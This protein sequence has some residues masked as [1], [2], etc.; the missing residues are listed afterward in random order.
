MVVVTVGT[1]VLVVVVVLAVVL[2]VGAVVV[3]VVLGVVD[4][5]VVVGAVVVVLAVVLVVGTVVVVVVLGVVDVVVVGAVVVVVLAVVDVVGAVVLVVVGTVVVVVVEPPA[6]IVVLARTCGA[7]EHV[8][9]IVPMWVRSTFTSRA[10]PKVTTP[11]WY[12]TTA[13]APVTEPVT[14]WEMVAPATSGTDWEATKLDRVVGVP[15]VT[16]ILNVASFAVT[17]PS[18][19]ACAPETSAAGSTAE[20]SNWVLYGV[21]AGADAGTV[22]TMV[23]ASVGFAWK[24]GIVDASSASTCAEDWTPLPGAPV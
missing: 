24:F 18:P 2:V 16:P 12:V 9:E 7:G 14:A 20:K 22:E 21:P 3:V 10:R 13:P 6:P 23:I 11:G 4:V 8:T 1:V 5:V 17:E 19:S 15:P